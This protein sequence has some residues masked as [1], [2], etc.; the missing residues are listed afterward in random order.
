MTLRHSLPAD[1]ILPIAPPAFYTRL[2][3]DFVCGK[4]EGHGD[5]HVLFMETGGWGPLARRKLSE[6]KATAGLWSEIEGLNRRLGAAG[7]AVENVTSL[8]GGET[9]AVVGG[10]QPGLLG[11]PLLVLYKAATCVALAERFQEVTGI[12]CAP[13]FV[14]SSDDSDLEEIKRCTLYDG[15]LRRLAL[16]FPEEAYVAGQ[17]VGS[18]S[19]EAEKEL[20]RSLQA[21]VGGA[22]GGDFVEGM[23]RAAAEVAADHGEFVAATLCGLFSD[24]GLVVVDG[25]SAEMRRAGAPAFKSY[26]KMRT[27]LRDAVRSA[28]EEMT[29]RGHHAQISGQGL[30]WWLFMNDGN[31][32]KK[33]GEE[34]VMGV[35]RAIDE[36][37]EKLSPNVALRPIWRDSVLPAVFCVCGPSEVAYSLQL[38][39]AYKMLGVTPPGLF[40][41]LSVTLIPGEGEDVAGGWME[42]GLSSLLNDFDGAVRSHYR[43]LAP[44]GAVSA[45]EKAKAAVAGGMKELAGSLAGVSAEL[46]KAAESV[47]RAS[48]KG[49]DRLENDIVDGVKRDAEA[50]NPRLK[51][52]GDFILPDGKLQERTASMLVPFLEEGG[53][54][55]ET[56]TSMARSHVHGCESGK[57]RHYCYRI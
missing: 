20:A 35:E 49:L 1:E 56:L 36:S 55:M 22:R 14:V 52:L 7:G 30:D 51:G 44:P 18:L 26:L 2:Y 45:L 53:T 6:R 46:G 37:P 38:R 31:V 42:A 19:A 47:L 24:R 57:V 12:R 41:R 17:V 9:V 34:S 50:R 11:G 32:R 25:R 15:S 3:T 8:A 10:Q 28:G 16:G 5:A 54:F 33:L 13:V 43:S 48:G 4:A 23:L 29:G 27:E 39:Q 40:P 21:S